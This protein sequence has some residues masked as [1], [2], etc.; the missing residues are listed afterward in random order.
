[1]DL[2]KYNAAVDDKFVDIAIINKVATV[3]V[4]PFSQ[5]KRRLK[6]LKAS[7]ESLLHVILPFQV[8][9]EA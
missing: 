7:F 2:S 4:G 8:L 1:M 6:R 5:E 3:I 9:A